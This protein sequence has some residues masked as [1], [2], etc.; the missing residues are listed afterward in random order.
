MGSLPKIVSE[1][2]E[3]MGETGEVIK[4]SLIWVVD[5]VINLLLI[6][7][8]KLSI[9]NTSFCN[10]YMNNLWILQVKEFYNEL[11]RILDELVEGKAEVYMAKFIRKGTEKFDSVSVDF[12]PP[13][14]FNICL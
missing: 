11:L 3:A 10:V 8:L 12:F 1:V 7:R 5:T 13:F 14:W 9:F 4:K 6:S 2:V